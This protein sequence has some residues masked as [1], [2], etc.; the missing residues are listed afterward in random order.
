MGRTNTNARHHA[1]ASERI[2]G[3]C[4]Y[5]ARQKTATEIRSATWDDW[6][7]ERSTASVTAANKIPANTERRNRLNVVLS[8]K[9]ACHM[10]NV[11]ILTFLLSIDTLRS[12]ISPLDMCT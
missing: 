12:I 1:T 10:L 3:F 4:Q 5:E 9:R 8:P 7:S 2:T 11:R 6:C